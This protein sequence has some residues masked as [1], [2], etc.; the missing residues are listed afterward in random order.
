MTPATLEYICMLCKCEDALLAA[1]GATL[2]A[3]DVVAE[4]AAGVTADRLESSFSSAVVPVAVDPDSGGDA[5]ELGVA[6]GGGTPAEVGA[7][8]V[9]PDEK[10]KANG[11][12]IRHS[13]MAI[14]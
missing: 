1:V 5:D 12:T 8:F 7:A 10:L 3:T 9:E 6:V 4:A 11:L 14:S 2:L 13:S